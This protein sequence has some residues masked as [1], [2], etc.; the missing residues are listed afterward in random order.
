MLASLAAPALVLFPLAAAQ[1]QDGGAAP[2]TA[3]PDLAPEEEPGSSAPVAAAPAQDATDGE[4]ERDEDGTLVLDEVVVEGRGLSLIGI[5]SSATEGVVGREELQRRPILRPGELLETV[6]GVIITQHSGAG[7]GNQFFLRGFNLDHGTDIAVR[8]NG[9]PNNLPSHGHGQ[10]YIDLNYLIPELTDTVKFRKGP[11]YADAGDFATAGSV[12][13]DYVDTLPNAMVLLE[14]GSF[15]YQRALAADSFRL[16]DGDLMFAFETVHED[17]PWE[18]PQ[19]F[20]KL[21][22][23]VRYTE[24]DV[25]G[26]VRY[27][28]QAYDSSWIA[29]DHVAK[30]AVDTG[31]IGRFGSLDPTSGGETSRYSLS[32]D[33]WGSGD[34]DGWNINAYTYF[35]GLDLYSN[36]TYAL[37]D[38]ANGDQFLQTDERWVQ[39]IEGDYNWPMELGSSFGENTIGF[40]FRNDII[41]NGLFD[42]AQRNIL[43]TT[44][45]DEILQTSLGL[46]AQ[47][48]VYWNDWFR[49][50]IGLRG[51]VYRFDVDSDLAVNSGTETDALVSPKAGVVFGPWS[52][53]EIYLQGGYGFHSN[54]ARGTTLS[55][56]PTTPAPNDGVPVDPLV[57]QRGAELGVRTTAVEGLQST[58][59]LWYLNSDSELLFVGDAGATEPTGATERFGVEWTNFYDVNTW[60]TLDLDL[61]ASQARFTGGGDNHVPGAIDEVA[62]MGATVRHPRGHYFAIRGRYFGPRDLTEDGTIQSSTSFLVNAHAGYRFSEDWQVRLSIFNLLD[63]EVSDIE[64]YYPSRLPGEAPGPDDGGYNDIHFHPS[65]PFSVRVGLFASF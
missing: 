16:G 36:F 48:Q 43:S 12:S 24:S 50:T 44:R 47:N 49:S 40:Q 14:A 39:G 7:K 13:I 45:Q 21:N 1:A 51:D 8:V 6:P 28:A 42:T 3:P 25:N 46:H 34:D 61:A 35:Y 62:A 56:D 30:R 5:A 53:T 64:Y 57:Q 23:V 55:D 41:D 52:D 19:N 15:D 29:T 33:W 63:R 27:T 17:G 65:E 59:S 20:N 26:G 32:A 4:L 9:I 11:Y 18:V 58:L 54:D 2:G 22:G 60:L 37:D 10:G 38:P 31:L